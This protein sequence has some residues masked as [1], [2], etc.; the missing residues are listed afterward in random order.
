MNLAEKYALECGVK[1]REPFV[2]VHFFPLN[3]DK[4][5][6]FD[7]RGKV[8]SF[9]YDLFSEVLEICG[10]SLRINGYEIIQ[11]MEEKDQKLPAGAKGF[12]ALNKKQEAYLV[13]NSDL[14]IANDNYSLQLASILKKKSIGLYSCFY[15][16]NVR[17][18]WNKEL[19]TIFESHRFG[20]KPGY[21]AVEIPKTI[22]LIK[23]EQVC[24]SIFD[25]LGISHSFDKVQTLHIGAELHQM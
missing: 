8:E 15:A 9:K 23:P 3:F 7:T 6:L 12:A 24:C 4:Y 2:D 11:L 21:G 10:K 22:N 14:V 20:N 16:E 1:L 19:Q 25:N 13:K 18:A 5:V 17:P